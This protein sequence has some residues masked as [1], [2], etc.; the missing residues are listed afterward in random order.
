M[1]FK[2]FII[3]FLLSEHILCEETIVIMKKTTY[4]FFTYLYVLTASKL[5]CAI[6]KVMYVCKCARV[7]ESEH[8][9]L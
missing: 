7:Y 4:R 6:V 8:D 5:V 2:N 1:I 3:P 9:S